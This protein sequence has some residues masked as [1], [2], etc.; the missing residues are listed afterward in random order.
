MSGNKLFLIQISYSIYF[1]GMKH[2]LKYFTIS[3]SISHL[4]LN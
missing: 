1:K 2:S 4:L 3:S